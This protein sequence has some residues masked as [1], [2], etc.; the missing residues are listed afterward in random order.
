MLFKDKNKS[1]A[2]FEWVSWIGTGIVALGTGIVTVCAAA[3]SIL[4][5]EIEKEEKEKK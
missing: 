3:I 1:K 4:N 5:K 2:N